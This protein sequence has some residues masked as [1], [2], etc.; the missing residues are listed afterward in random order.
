ML[1]GNV[2][3][4]NQREARVARSLRSSRTMYHCIVC[5]SGPCVTRG[6]RKPAMRAHYR[7]LLSDAG[8]H[9]VFTTHKKYHSEQLRGKKK[10]EWKTIVSKRLAP[11]LRR[12]R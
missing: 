5:G 3:C 6:K 4:K 12:R 7:A 9:A 1:V 2:L 10:C 8:T 11:M